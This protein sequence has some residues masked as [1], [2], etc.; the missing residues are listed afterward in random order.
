[1]HYVCKEAMRRFGAAVLGSLV[2]AASMLILPAAAGAA[3]VPVITAKPVISGTPQVGVESIATATWTGDPPPTVAWAWFR[4]AK[5]T[6][7]CSTIS[8]AASDRY[9]PTVADIGSVLRVRVTVSNV[10]GSDESRSDA[11]AVVAAASPAPAATPTPTATPPPTP[12]PAPPATPVTQPAFDI[13]AVVVAPPPA[14]VP[15]EVPKAPVPAMLRPF[16]VIRIKGVLTADGAR[17]SLLS[18]RGP[19]DARVTVVCRGRDCPVRR[20]GPV[21][22]VRRLHRFE[23]NLRAGTRLELT[24]T[25]RGYIGKYTV[26]VIRRGAAPW[27]SDRCLMP[28]TQRVI[29]CAPA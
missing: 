26:I 28:D 25:K 9:R 12:D 20:F 14:V 13:S 27:R 22:G 24:V 8:G 29:R 1:V 19:K 16:P 3:T 11:S 5:A 2:A 7:P 10:A 23:R 15:V 4:C 21:R 6:G 17:V 18:V